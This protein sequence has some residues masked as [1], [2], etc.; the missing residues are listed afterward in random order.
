MKNVLTA[1]WGTTEFPQR[2]EAGSFRLPASITFHGVGCDRTRKGVFLQSP[3]EYLHVARPHQLSSRSSGSTTPA[4]IDKSYRAL[5]RGRRGDHA[6]QYSCDPGTP[7]YTIQ[8]ACT[9]FSKWLFAFRSWSG[10]RTSWVLSPQLQ[11]RRFSRWIHVLNLFR[12]ST[13]LLKS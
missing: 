6:S 1:S 2:A 12:R 13:L 8:R 11:F 3:D 7:V 9:A 4:P 10:Y 5:V